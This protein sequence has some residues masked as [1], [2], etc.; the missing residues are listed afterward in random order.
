MPPSEIEIAIIL[1]T[2]DD[3]AHIAEALFFP[4]VSRF[5]DNPET[6][7]RA[8]V[9]NCVQLL[10]EESPA[11]I[12]KRTLPAEIETTELTLRLEPPVR[13][14][15]WRGPIDLRL[16]VVR[17]SHLDS[18][19]IAFIPALG[20][21][22]VSNKADDSMLE[23]HARAELMR[24]RATTSLKEL[25]MLERTRELSL[26]RVR[27]MATIRSPKQIAASA[28]QPEEKK[29]SALEQTAN[30]LTK[31]KL[32]RAYE[33]EDA[34]ARL[35]EA[36]TGKSARSVLLVGKAGVGKTAVFNELVRRRDE[37]N[38]ASTPFWATSGSRLVAG[39]SGFG[40]WQ[41]RCDAA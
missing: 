6:L 5:G 41:E 36:L 2:F 26:M 29:S 3:D 34:V 35:A 8:I 33:V 19:H 22:V 13:R 23:R 15:T 27:S 17:W 38:L 39:M 12:F 20:I 14:L 31:Q 16:D 7:K 10:Q 11:L 21:E 40:M 30:D 24:R 32:S 25:I 1:R 4:E 18:A 28:G 9:K 37:F